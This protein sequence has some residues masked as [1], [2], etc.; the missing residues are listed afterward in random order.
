[1]AVFHKFRRMAQSSTA[2]RTES[3][4]V[5][6][7]TRSTAVL[8]NV[9]PETVKHRCPHLVVLERGTARSPRVAERR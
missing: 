1:M 5:M 9:G 6:G 7:H 3:V 4:S 8:H 2:Y